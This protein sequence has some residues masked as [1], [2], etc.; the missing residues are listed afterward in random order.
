MRNVVFFLLGVFYSISVA[1]QEWTPCEWPSMKHYDSN[2]L[3][4]IA[5]PLGGIGTGTVSLGG[6]GELRDWEI[7]NTPAKNY[8]TV[9]TGN[10]APFFAIYTKS[11]KGTSHTTLLTGPLHETEYLHYEG[12]GVNHHGMPRF[13]RASF[14]AAYPFGQVNLS[15]DELP[16]SVRIKGFTPFVPCNDEYS[17]KPIAI[18]SYEVKNKTNCDIEVAIC[19]SARNFIGKDGSKYKINWKGDNVPYGANANKNVYRSEDGISGIYMYSDGVEKTDPAYG[20][21]AIATNATDGVTYRT[22]SS[23]D[24]WNNAILDFWDDFSA[25][26]ELTEKYFKFRE[27]I[28]K[29]APIPDVKLPDP[30]KKKNYGEVKFTHSAK[31][32]DNLDVLSTPVE[33]VMPLTMEKLN[34][35]YGFVLYKAFVRGPRDEQKVRLQDVHDRGYIY[36]NGGFVGI[37]YRNDKEPMNSIAIEAEGAELAV[38]V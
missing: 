17:S 16:V 20:T 11:K 24:N 1:A 33:S 9:T 29:Y 23:R 34:Q 37:Q 26:G 3:Y 10:N 13:A 18:L 8:S 6:R 38:L 15:D 14:D 4:R 30:I 35:G 12:R 22:S 5:L 2:H 7:M 36:K 27:V 31:L 19:A 28:S 32:F 25:D 21:M